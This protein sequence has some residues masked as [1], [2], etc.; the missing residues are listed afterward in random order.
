MLEARLDQQGVDSP[1]ETG[2]KGQQIAKWREMKYKVTIEYD[3]G[4]TQKGYQR[5]KSLQTRDL[6][7]L[8]EE[9]GKEQH[10]DEWT[11]TDDERSVRCR[12]KEHRRVLRQEIERAACNAKGHHQELV[13]PGAAEPAEVTFPTLPFMRG[14]N[15]A[16]SQKQYVGNDK[17]EGEYLRRTETSLKQYLRKDEGAAPDGYRNKRNKMILH[18]LTSLSRCHV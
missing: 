3:D 10:G 15:D 9:H 2:A 11:R 7:R 4:H 12:S 8:P 1:A 16:I 14:I 5:A 17:A 6:L 18:L 13:S